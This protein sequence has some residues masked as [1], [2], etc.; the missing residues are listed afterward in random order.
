MRNYTA[1]YIDLKGKVINIKNFEA[2]NLKEANNK[3]SILK[4]QIQI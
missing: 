4:E 2:K 1:T 3:P